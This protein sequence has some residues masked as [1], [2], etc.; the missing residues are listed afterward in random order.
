MEQKMKGF[1]RFFNTINNNV[2]IFNYS[3]VDDVYNLQKRL[4]AKIITSEFDEKILI[5]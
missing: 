1:I 2:T 4:S 3:P 5:F